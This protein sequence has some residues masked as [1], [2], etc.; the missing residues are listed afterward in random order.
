MTTVDT[1]RR[2]FGGCKPVRVASDGWSEEEE[3]KHPRGQPKN[4]GQFGPGGG[5][6][7]ESG[8][9]NSGSSPARAVSFASL[10]A[11]TDKNAPLKQRISK[12]LP[13]GITSEVVPRLVIER[14]DNGGSRILKLQKGEKLEHQKGCT[15][16]ESGGVFQKGAGNLIVSTEFGHEEA[17]GLV[18]HEAFHALDFDGDR[19]LFTPKERK[20][21]LDYS[22][23][24]GAIKSSTLKEYLSMYEGQAKRKG[25]DGDELKEYVHR[26]ASSEI[27]SHALEKHH[28]DRNS[29]VSHIID[30]IESGE[31]AA[32]AKKAWSAERITPEQ[33]KAF[34]T[35]TSNDY[36]AINGDLRTAKGN[37]DQSGKYADTIK[38]LDSALDNAS[39]PGGTVYR[40]QTGRTFERWLK[41]GLIKPGEEITDFGFMSTSSDE[42][43]ASSFNEEANSLSSGSFK[44]AKN[45]LGVM[46][47]ISLPKGSKAAHVSDLSGM[48]D[49]KETLLARGTRLR[50]DKWD[51][52]KRECHVTAMPP[53]R[54]EKDRPAPARPASVGGE[55]RDQKPFSG[56]FRRAARNITTSPSKPAPSKF[57]LRAKNEE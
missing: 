24:S 36:T 29:P 20:E 57:T 23:K 8:R 38:H 39:Y 3:K 15:Y 19:G 49:E 26:H 46:F 25:L 53:I 31:I 33:K 11:K 16:Y 27:I 52:Q 7:S 4:A 21:L 14:S 10:G 35:Y 12:M 48:P 13:P 22:M 37:V 50:I 28:S 34:E 51:P 43:I 17:E 32:R 56:T 5:G 1:I 47:K 42:K 55:R 54:I 40:G 44:S 9:K 45:P 6:G 18:W 41:E 30:K 2:L